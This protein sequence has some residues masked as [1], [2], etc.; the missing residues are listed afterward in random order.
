VV[1]HFAIGLLLV[2]VVLDAIGW[3]S[4]KL[5][6]HSAA[7]VNLLAGGVSALFAV[8]TGVLAE[9]AAPE[10]EAIHGI[11]ERHELVGFAVLAL[12]AG[13]I[14]WRFLLRGGVPGRFRIFYMVASAVLAALLVYGGYL[15]GELVYRHG[16]GVKAKPSPVLQLEEEEDEPG[17]HG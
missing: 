6:F 10:T 11:V 8:V 9:E 2:A 12:A 5:I 1:V 3:L 15:G 17:E 4:R 7:W 16:V 14:L 13:L